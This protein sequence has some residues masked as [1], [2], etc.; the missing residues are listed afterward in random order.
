MKTKPTELFEAIMQNLNDNGMNEGYSIFAV[1][2]IKEYKEMLGS[3]WTNDYDN[4]KLSETRVEKI[5]DKINE[6][7]RSRNK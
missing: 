4:V 3:T 7:V 6:I 1:R 2:Y 5:Q